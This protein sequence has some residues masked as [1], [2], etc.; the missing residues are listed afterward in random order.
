ML[1]VLIF[2]CV[3][4]CVQNIRRGG[5]KLP[6]LL[7]RGHY[8][9]GP[10]VCQVEELRRRRQSVG[11]TCTSSPFESHIISPFPQGVD[12]RSTVT[13]VCLM[14]AEFEDYQI[15]VDAAITF[16]LKELR[17]RSLIP[18]RVSEVE[19]SPS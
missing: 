11:R 7:G 8:D 2:L 5:T 9:S 13:E 4:V 15:G 16:C 6:L 14:P 1:A 19:D 18:P 3:C 12:T 17:V 10:R